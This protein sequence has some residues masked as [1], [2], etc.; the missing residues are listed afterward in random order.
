MKKKGEI[1]TPTADS[2]ENIEKEFSE[3]ATSIEK[4][5]TFDEFVLDAAL[6][7][8]DEAIRVL[9]HSGYDQSSVVIKKLNMG[10]LSL[11][12]IKENQSLR[13][14]YEAIYNQVVVIWVSVLEATLESLFKFCIFQNYPSLGETDPVELKVSLARIV[15]YDTIKE[16]FPTLVREADR[17]IS[18]QNMESIKRTFHKY[19][20]LDFEETEDLHNVSF[21]M[22]ARH[23]IVHDGGRVDA[24]F[25]K[26][27]KEK[28]AE[29]TV[30]KDLSKPT[31]QFKLAEARQISR[32]FQHFVKNLL[33]KI[34]EKQDVKEEAKENIPF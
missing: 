4:L 20:G 8:Y 34:R 6:K 24:S 25:R 17:S 3:Y 26:Y 15:S 22:A 19:L 28:L 31:L 13:P 16:A 21:A 32:S 12:N 30:M 14:S 29:R 23:T 2:L 7:H 5:L 1:V 18:F 33:S 11:A 9:E 27:A 10:R